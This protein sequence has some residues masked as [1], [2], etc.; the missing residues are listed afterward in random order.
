MAH[1]VLCVPSAVALNLEL[2]RE[3][4][5]QCTSTELQP[6][7]ACELSENVGGKSLVYKS[8]EDES[9]SLS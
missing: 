4:V 7:A 1:F 9:M 6:F 5:C 3:R 8:Y 2:Y